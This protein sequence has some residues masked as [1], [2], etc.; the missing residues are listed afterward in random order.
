MTDA[1]KRSRVRLFVGAILAAYAVQLAYVMKADEPYPALMMPRFG[2]AGP[3]QTDG[4]DVTEAEIEFEYA[5]GA[6]RHLTLSE[7]MESAPEGHRFTIVDN[8]LS[9]LP[10]VDAE[11]RAPWNKI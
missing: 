11:R 5:G 9:P 10:P 4:L 3:P 1:A 8:L 2:W 6:T 7:L